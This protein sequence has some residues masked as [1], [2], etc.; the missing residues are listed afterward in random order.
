M[1]HEIRRAARTAPDA[2]P[3]AH[4]APDGRSIVVD[5]QDTLDNPLFRVD[6]AS[7]RVTRLTREGTAHN[8]RGTT[9]G[10]AAGVTGSELQDPNLLE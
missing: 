4:W 3:S 2:G 5:A 9:S 8:A 6:V 7:G 1:V 10:K